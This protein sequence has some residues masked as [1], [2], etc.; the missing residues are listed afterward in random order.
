MIHPFF[1]ILSLDANDIR[2]RK[3]EFFDYLLN[4]TDLACVCETKLNEKIRFKHTDFKV[5][6]LD[7]N[8]GLVTRGG[9]A[10]VTCASLQCEVLP[11]L[12]TEIIETLGVRVPTRDGQGYVDIYAS[13]YTGTVADQD[14]QA[15]R[16]DIQRMTYDIQ[17]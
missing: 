16:R 1:R 8:N 2:N 11:S 10:V 17:E 7:N 9:V 4:E 13:Y 15:F 3:L 5:Y 12:N 6:I 14:N